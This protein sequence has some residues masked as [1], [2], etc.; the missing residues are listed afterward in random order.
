MRASWTHIDW[1]RL[2]TALL[3][4]LFALREFAAQLG[5]GRFRKSC[6]VQ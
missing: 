2:A 4:T 1:N 5:V 6:V 3:E